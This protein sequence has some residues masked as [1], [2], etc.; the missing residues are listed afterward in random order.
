MFKGTP[1]GNRRIRYKC[2]VKKFKYFF[3][4]VDQVDIG[5]SFDIYTLDSMDG[6]RSLVIFAGLKS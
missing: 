3:N 6:N 5:V 2:I 4:L 1:F